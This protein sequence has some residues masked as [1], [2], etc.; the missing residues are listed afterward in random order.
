M[1]DGE[2]S[3][4]S[5]QDRLQSFLRLRVLLPYFF[6]V[7]SLALM[8]V[9]ILFRGRLSQAAGYPAVFLITYFSNVSIIPLPGVVIVCF[10]AVK[11]NPLLVGL[12]GAFASA[13]GET[14]VYLLGASGAEVLKPEG[15]VY[16]FTQAWLQRSGLLILFLLAALPNPFADVAGAVAGVVRYPFWRFVGVVLVGKMLK[17]LVMSYGCYYGLA[18]LNTVLGH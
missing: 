8:A 7:L 2:K 9:G 12:L 6:V 1:T 5:S 15:K 17:F 10:E 3:H 14:T 4:S 18:W 16:K 11:L 13:A